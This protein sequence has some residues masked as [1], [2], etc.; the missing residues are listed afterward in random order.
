MDNDGLHWPTEKSGSIGLKAGYHSISVGYFQ[1]SGNMVLN[2]S[3]S[4]SDLKKQAIP[5]SMLFRS[6]TGS[7]LRNM[8][9]SSRTTATSIQNIDS[10]KS[11]SD[12]A[13]P[14]GIKAYPNPFVNS[15][16]VTITGD[17]GDYQLM[18][19]DV[20]GRALWR[21]IGTKSA[22]SF[23]ETISTSALQKGIYFLRIIQNNNRSVFKLEK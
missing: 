14:P 13:I 12:F 16:K 1:Q 10:A 7:S 5:N 11:Q 20:S 4:G 19:V 9:S 8:N 6:G 17:A 22:G 23:Q 3:Y 15:V 21:K 2:V 18:L